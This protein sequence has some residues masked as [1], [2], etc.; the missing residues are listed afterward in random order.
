MTENLPSLRI[1]EI[2][3]KYN[4]AD[5]YFKSLGIN[6]IDK[7]IPL[8]KFVAIIGDD[9][10]QNIGL[11]RGQLIEHFCSFIAKMESLKIRITI[12]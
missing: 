8:D 2:F 7:N 5:D 9:V 3:D 4:Y 10:L 11:D 6:D 12:H 1:E